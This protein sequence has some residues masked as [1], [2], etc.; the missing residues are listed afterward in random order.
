LTPDATADAAI[1]TYQ[2][3]HVFFAFAGQN[4]IKKTGDFVATDLV[5]KFD[6]KKCVRKKTDS[7]L[8]EPKSN[9]VITIT[10][11]TNSLL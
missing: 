9:S 11:I 6:R 1:L 10:D 3:L 4:I 2:S 7:V 5:R 8:K